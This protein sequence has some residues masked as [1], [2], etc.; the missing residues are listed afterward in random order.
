MPACQLTAETEVK[1]LNH[2]AQGAQLIDAAREAGVGAGTVRRWMK[3]GREGTAP[4]AEFAEKVRY[5]EA[6]PRVRAEVA[7]DEA[8]LGGTVNAA[9]KRLERLDK[10][11]HAE[12]N[13]DR[14]H[15]EL[16]QV[17]EDVLGEEALKKVLRAYVE[18]SG[19]E[20]TGGAR[21]SIRLVA[22]Q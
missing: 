8:I 6:M 20:E 16:L 3:L 4:Y 21:A 14:Q 12:S 17:I 18:R 7:I 5:S 13:V 22:S 19:S 9:F 2:V 1:I 15:E 11:A 10:Q